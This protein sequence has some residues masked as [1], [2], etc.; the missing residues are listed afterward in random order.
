MTVQVCNDQCFV[1]DCFGGRVGSDRAIQFFFNNLG[2][3]V[4]SKT[5]PSQST[6]NQSFVLLTV[7]G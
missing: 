2:K 3:V 5:M 4:G 6:V 7:L 1:Y